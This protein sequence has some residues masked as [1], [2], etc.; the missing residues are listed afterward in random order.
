MYNWLWIIPGVFVLYFTVLGICVFLVAQMNGVMFYA[1]Q[2]KQWCFSV[3]SKAT[4]NKILKITV[5]KKLY[6][7]ITYVIYARSKNGK[8]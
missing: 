4:S 5:K 2:E 3:G 8:I 7:F 1:K 6:N